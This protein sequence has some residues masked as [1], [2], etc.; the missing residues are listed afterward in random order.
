MSKNASLPMKTLRKVLLFLNFAAIA[1]Y[2][3]FFIMLLLLLTEL[4][5]TVTNCNQ[6]CIVSY[7]VHT[8]NPAPLLFLFNI[9]FDF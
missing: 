9:V 4:V 6:M 3:Y 5:L 1:L 7:R 2:T 8:Y